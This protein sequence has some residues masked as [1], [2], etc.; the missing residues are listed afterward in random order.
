MIDE[1]KKANDRAANEANF[2]E[3]F[4][5]FSVTR[6]LGHTDMGDISDS[7]EVGSAVNKSI[8][9]NVNHYISRAN[10]EE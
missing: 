7:L 5:E 3:D 6:K 2:Q 10:I 9:G 8:E 4:N 1:Q